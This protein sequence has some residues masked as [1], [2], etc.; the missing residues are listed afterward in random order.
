MN[1]NNHFLFYNREEAEKAG[2]VRVAPG[3]A[4]SGGSLPATP[5]SPPELP[6]P[7][8]GL[9]RMSDWL[10]A[11]AQVAAQVEEEE[12]TAVASGEIPAGWAAPPEY[13]VGGRS[14]RGGAARST[15]RL[16]VVSSA[17]SSSSSSSSVV[18]DGDACGSA[19]VPCYGATL[20][21]R[22]ALGGDGFAGAGGDAVGARSVAAGH[23]PPRPLGSAPTRSL[24]PRLSTQRL[25]R[26]VNRTMHYLRAGSGTPGE[27]DETWIRR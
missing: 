15:E 21:E 10:E 18:G 13:Q 20:E 2:H 6:A 23:H 3:A 16:N 27:R 7:R 11:A 14:G 5:P 17:R 19:G 9:M 25:S 12:A 8:D 24:S 1:D 26:S 22:G 4:P